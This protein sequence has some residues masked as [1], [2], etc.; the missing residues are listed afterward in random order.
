MDTKKRDELWRKTLALLKA[1]S[2]NKDKLVEM[3]ELVNQMVKDFSES[4][5][6]EGSYVLG[7]SYEHQY[8]LAKLQ[9]TI[10][11]LRKEVEDMEKL[12]K[13][14]QAAYQKMDADLKIREQI[15]EQ[16]RKKL[17]FVTKGP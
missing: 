13:N 3:E 6:R 5:K 1:M 11:H 14:L 8:L 9:S 17:Q 2:T 15:R 10:E 4:I 7:N 12:E 16:L